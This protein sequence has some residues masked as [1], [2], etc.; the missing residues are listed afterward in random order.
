MFLF[1][2]VP[3][4]ANFPGTCLPRTGN[5]F[6]VLKRALLALPEPGIHSLLVAQ[7]LWTSCHPLDCSIP[8]SMGFSREEYWNGLPF[9]SP[10]DLPSPGLLY[11]FRWI[12][13]LRATREAQNKH[14]NTALAGNR[15][16]VSVWEGRILP[17][18]NQCSSRGPVCNDCLVGSSIQVFRN[19]RPLMPFV[20]KTVQAFILR[21]PRY[22]PLSAS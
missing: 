16:R 11:I 4:T 7:S 20:S 3:L 2:G 8:L 1:F 15:T 21:P 12:L 19:C 10:G 13:Y 18:N 17:L 22:W 9:P 6:I 14:H 5:S